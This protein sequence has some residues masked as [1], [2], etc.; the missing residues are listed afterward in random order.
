MF[1]LINGVNYN[2]IESN[3][4]GNK[5]EQMKTVTPLSDIELSVMF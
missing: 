3:S 1:W 5:E 2:E 4:V